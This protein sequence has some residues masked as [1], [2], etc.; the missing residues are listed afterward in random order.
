MTA[1]NIRM[2][3]RG[4]AVWLVIIAAEIL[5]GAIRV[6]FLEPLVGDFRARQ[7]AVLAGF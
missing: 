3:G 4:F 5:H 1:E 7:I 2:I 6:M